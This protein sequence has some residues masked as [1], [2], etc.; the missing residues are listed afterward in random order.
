MSRSACAA[1]PKWIEPAHAETI[2]PR[3]PRLA[4]KTR[5]GF[6]QVFYSV[7]CVVLEFIHFTSILTS[8]LD[9]MMGRTEKPLYSPATFVK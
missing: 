3:V 8:C 6:R 4:L 7:Y 9:P 2:E 5:P 1:L